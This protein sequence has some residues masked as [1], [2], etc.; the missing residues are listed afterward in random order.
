MPLPGT[1]L[2]CQPCHRLQEVRATESHPIPSHP[3]LSSPVLPHSLPCCPI[4]PCLIQ[5]LFV[6]PCPWGADHPWDFAW[7]LGCRQGA[8]Q[9]PLCCRQLFDPV[10]CISCDRPL[11]LAPVL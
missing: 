1:L 4:L 11:A 6:P 9:L 7:S 10:K 8:E 2:R 3:L 5:T